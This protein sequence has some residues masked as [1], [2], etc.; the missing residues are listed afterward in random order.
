M[1]CLWLM[2]T[3]EQ[4]IDGAHAACWRHDEACPAFSGVCHTIW[5]RYR[6][7]CTHYRCTDR[8][9]PPAGCSRLIDQLSR[10]RGY[11]V[12]LFIWR[13]MA[14]QAGYSRM[15]QQWC[16]LHAVRH[17]IGDQLGCK[18]TPG[19]WHFRAARLGDIDGLVVIQ[20]PSLFDIVVVYGKAIG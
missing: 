20:W 8:N 4:G 11:P 9:D 18:C 5:R 12:E 6:L 19:R 15:Q 16:N 3:G 13:F 17:Q 2:Q 7:Q 1:G 10:L 14:L